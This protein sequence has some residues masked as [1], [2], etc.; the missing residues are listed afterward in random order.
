[1]RNVL[2]LLERTVDGEE[3]SSN[4]QNEFLNDLDAAAVI[5]VFDEHSILNLYGAFCSADRCSQVQ[6]QRLMY[7]D[8]S[9]L[10][11]AGSMFIAPAL[12]QALRLLIKK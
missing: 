8:D 3:R 10:S 6:N 1:M 2:T 12:E 11:S 7:E 9:H 5:E 4:F